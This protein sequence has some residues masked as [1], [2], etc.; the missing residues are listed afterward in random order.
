MQDS[1][2]ESLEHRFLKMKKSEILP[3]LNVISVTIED[4]Y[5][6]QKEAWK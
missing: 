3:Q 4:K 2:F 5:L 6:F 1:A